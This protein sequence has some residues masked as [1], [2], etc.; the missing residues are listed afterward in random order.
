MTSSQL[1]RG[2]PFWASLVAIGGLAAAAFMVSTVLNHASADTSFFAS[3]DGKPP[4]PAPVTSANTPGWDVSYHNRGVLGESARSTFERPEPTDGEH[5]PNCEAPPATH[6]ITTYDGSAYR[7]NDH[8]MTAINSSAYGVLYLTPASMVDFSQ[9]EATISWDMS[10]NRDSVRDWV[11]I[12][13]TPYG[14]HLHAPLATMLLSRGKHVLL[15]KPMAITPEECEQIAAAAERSEGVL[16]IGMIRRFWDSVPWTRALIQEG[17]LG[18]VESFDIRDGARNIAIASDFALRRESSGGGVLM[19]LGVHVLDQ[20]LYWFGPVASFEYR[21]DAYGG[22]EANCELDLVMESGARGTVE[23]S[24]V[25]Q[26][27]GTAIIRGTRGELELELYG[28]GIRATPESLLDLAAGGVVGRRIPPSSPRLAP[29]FAREIGDWL[30]AA[31]EGRPPRVPGDRHHREI[32]ELI[33]D[34]YAHRQELDLPWMHPERV[35][36][37]A[38]PISP[39]PVGVAAHASAAAGPTDETARRNGLRSL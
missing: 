17:G 35:L 28:Q 33:R 15:E 26:M 4:T 29:I 10:T 24:F 37:P 3:F 1:R 21:D 16:A 18:E 22:N 27:R 39:D 32:A 14:H 6:T 25:L 13:I 36:D 5:G 31:L 8:L 9:G 2:R 12:W 7:C 23:L 30:G 11:D 38:A 20:L 34:C 19:N